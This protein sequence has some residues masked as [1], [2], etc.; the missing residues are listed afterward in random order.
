M[1]FHD[2]LR[3]QRRDSG[4]EFLADQS[5]RFRPRLIQEEPVE[6]HR[7]GASPMTAMTHIAIAEMLD[8]TPVQWMEKVT[9]QQYGA[10]REE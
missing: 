10:V 5:G 8:G 7:H 6:K 3:R 2:Q 4:L 9:D 1:A